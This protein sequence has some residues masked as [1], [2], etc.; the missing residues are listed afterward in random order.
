MRLCLFQKNHELCRPG[1]TP[2]TKRSSGTPYVGRVRKESSS[3]RSLRG[4]FDIVVSDSSLI[5]TRHPSFPSTDARRRY[6]CSA[7]TPTG[8]RHRRQVSRDRQ[9]YSATVRQAA[10]HCQ[11]RGAAHQAN[12]ASTFCIPRL[13]IGCRTSC[14]PYR[15]LQHAYLFA[16]RLRRDCVKTSSIATI[17]LHVSAKTH[18][19]SSSLFQSSAASTTSQP[20]KPSLRP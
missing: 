4:V 19:P 6:Q 15:H 7:T 9:L 14:A 8:R 12:L 13:S 5:S 2:A 20:S 10:D 1:C 16:T 11:A 18:S 17:P 3:V